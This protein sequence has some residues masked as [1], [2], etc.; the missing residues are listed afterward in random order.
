MGPVTSKT[1]IEFRGKPIEI[2][3][4]DIIE[5]KG[6]KHT[7]IYIRCDQPKLLIQP[8]DNKPRSLWAT[9]PPRKWVN[10]ASIDSI[11]KGAR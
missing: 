4:G 9:K 10:I 11:V 5:Y 8:I 3:R 2:E 6:K 1:M 7:L